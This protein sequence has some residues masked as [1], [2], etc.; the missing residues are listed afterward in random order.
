[1]CVQG[2][3]PSSGRYELAA[4]PFD[5]GWSTAGGLAFT[6]TK[7]ALAGWIKDQPELSRD[8]RAWEAAV[9]FMEW[10]CEAEGVIGRLAAR[11]LYL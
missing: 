5:R 10:L 3:K 8:P 11:G 2:E 6:L 7:R 1:M 4:P 9:L